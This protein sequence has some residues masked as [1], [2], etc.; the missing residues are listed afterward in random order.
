MGSGK[1]KNPRALSNIS[2]VASLRP[3]YIKNKYVLVEVIIIWL[4]CYLKSNALLSDEL[5][6]QPAYELDD[7]TCFSKKLYSHLNPQLRTLQL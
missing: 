1:T 4:L 5:Q 6:I 7:M 3:I 2:E